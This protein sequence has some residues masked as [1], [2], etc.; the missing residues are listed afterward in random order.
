MGRRMPTEDPSRGFGFLVHDVARLLRREFDRRAREMGLTRAQWAVIAH[1]RRNEG[2]NQAGLAELVEIAPITLA[3]LLDRMEAAGW[4]ERRPDPADRRARRLYLTDRA[5]AE[6]KVVRKVAREVR[7]KA[8]AGLT[9]E[10]T[11]RL[12]AA[13]TQ[14]K[15][16]LLAAE[17]PPGT[18]RPA[19]SASRG[20]PERRRVY[21]SEEARR[22]RSGS[23]TGS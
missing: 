11:A 4:I 15:A 14:V 19:P 2:I 23:R 18:A 21:R 17:T 12:M 16:N 3:R 10:D 7:A 5:R 13:L 20:S 9:A 1:L 6:L 8:L 22:A